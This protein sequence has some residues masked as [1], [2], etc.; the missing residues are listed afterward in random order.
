M[1]KSLFTLLLAVLL[2]AQAQAQVVITEISYNPPESGTDSLEYVEL[3]NNSANQVDVSGWTF[4]QGFEY[5]FPSGTILN[6]GEY[7]VI[8][9]TY[10]Y[11]FDI[12]GFYPLVWVS[13][14]ALTN[15]GED[16]ELRNAAGTVIDYVDYKNIA[17][18]PTTANG[19]GPSIVLCNPNADNSLPENWSACTTATGKIVNNFEIF[20]NP[21]AASNCASSIQ[22]FDDAATVTS[23]GTV[24]IAVSANDFK[25][26]PIQAVT[27]VTNP[28][29]GTATVNSLG[30]LVYVSTAGYCGAD[31]LTYRICEAGNVCDEAKV[32]ITVTC[33]PL[34]TIAQMTTENAAGV[35]DSVGK[36]CVLEGIVNITNLRPTGLQ[37]S[38]QDGGAGIAVFRGTGGFGYTPAIGN[39]IRVQ[40]TIQQFNGLNQIVADTVTVVSMFNSIVPLNQT[41]V[42]EGNESEYI[43][44]QRTLRLVDPAQ[45]TTGMGTGFSVAAVDIASP[46]DTIS[47]RVD[48]DV[49]DYFNAP[50]PSGNFK[51]QGICT[52]FD[53]SNPFTSGYQIL[54]RQ[55]GDISVSAFEPLQVQLVVAPNPV[56]QVLRINMSEQ[57]ERISVTDASGRAVIDFYQPDLERTIDVS[58]WKSGV[59]QITLWKGGR[60]VTERVVKL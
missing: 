4:T 40:G 10:Q 56:T 19:M 23:G 42:N 36:T 32:R 3:L 21:G 14:G 18:W 28:V 29:G 22:A 8:S 20:A 5:E 25:P 60:S 35:A 49:V 16:I 34:R 9:K 59:Y 7:V 31:S 46:T 24:T 2:F 15:G 51:I 47:I 52:Q 50:A 6:P 12:F 45:W 27:I 48:N 33:Y 1:N 58:A 11:F 44:I 57:V 30:E 41:N 53:S 38:I 13:G 17:P 54:P 37:F 55:I 43:E 26:N 39:R